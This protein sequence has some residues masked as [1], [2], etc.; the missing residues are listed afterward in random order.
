MGVDYSL[1][2]SQLEEFVPTVHENTI[3][4]PYLFEE[5]RVGFVWYLD[6]FYKFPLIKINLHEEQLEFNH[7]G[8]M[9]RMPFRDV[10]GFALL[11]PL[12]E[13]MEN[14]HNS[15]NIRFKENKAK[16]LL[17]KRRIGDYKIFIYRTVYLK[18]H[19]ENVQING[20][21]PEPRFVA[22]SIYYVEKG[23]WLY[24]IRNKKEV[25]EHLEIKHIKKAKTFIKKHKLKF[26]KLEDYTHLFTYLQNIEESL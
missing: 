6:S 11:N 23:N 18:I 20:T 12:T 8:R 16:G 17:E 13:E 10:N 24:L 14:F 21:G 1:I 25:L 4:E 9:K 5:Y 15:D 3:G 26:K 19:S 22:R 2:T 7:M